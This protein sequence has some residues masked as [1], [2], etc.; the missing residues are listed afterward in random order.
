MKHLS[1][2]ILF[3]IKW[4]ACVSVCKKDPLCV[5]SAIE[6][7]GH[8]LDKW[9]VSYICVEYNMRFSQHGY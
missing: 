9:F 2:V 1:L 5:P 4:N 3:K 6:T 7:R 8:Y